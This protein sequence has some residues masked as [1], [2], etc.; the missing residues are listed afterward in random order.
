MWEDLRVGDLIQNVHEF[1]ET[2]GDENIKKQAEKIKKTLQDEVA[3][4]VDNQFTLLK[5]IEEKLAN[6]SKIQTLDKFVKD[7][8]KSLTQAGPKSKAA[9]DKVVDEYAQLVK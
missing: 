9:K 5:N 2:N 4:D 1:I 7:I 3:P 6:E 8:Y